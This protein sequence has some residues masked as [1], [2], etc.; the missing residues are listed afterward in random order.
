ML[1]VFPANTFAESDMQASWIDSPW[2]RMTHGKYHIVNDLT[3]LAGEPRRTTAD[4]LRFLT[5]TFWIV[6]PLLKLTG[7]LIARIWYTDV[8]DM[9]ALIVENP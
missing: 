7:T 3:T 5:P 9:P 2:T 4:R 6:L 1:T 8:F